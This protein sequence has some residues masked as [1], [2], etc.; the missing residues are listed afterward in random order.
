VD[1]SDDERDRSGGITPL[2]G[3]DRTALH[4]VPD[5]DPALRLSSGDPR[6]QRRGDQREQ[7]HPPTR[8]K[9]PNCDEM[10]ETPTILRGWIRMKT[11]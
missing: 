7:H 5:D 10:R 1:D 4:G 2:V 3:D 9:P 8:G 11:H 6:R